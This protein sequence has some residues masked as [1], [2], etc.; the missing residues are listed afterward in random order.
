MLI[1][2]SK[3]IV[4][5]PQSITGGPELLHQLVDELR[6]H[7]R[8]ACIVYYPFD[9]IF[10]CPEP[11]TKY[12]APQG[13]FI[14]DDKN[15]IIVPETATAIA[16]GI[17]NA[18]VGIWWL[19][20]DNYL[21]AMHQSRL[22]DIYLRYKS[23]IRHRMPLRSMR[24]F[25]HFTQSY[26]AAHFLNTA[27]I[28]SISL[29]DYLSREHLT[30]T[31]SGDSSSKE[32]IIVYNSKKGQR[33]TSALMK[34][35]PNFRFVPILNMTPNQVAELL[36]KAKVYVDFGHHPGKDRPPREAAMAG[37]CVI[38]GRKGSA[39]FH[40]DIPIPE[41]YKLNDYGSAYLKTF[42]PLVTRIYK[43]FDEYVVDFQPYRDRIIHEGEIFK[44]QVKEIFG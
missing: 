43:N 37:C 21:L 38:T 1:T 14:D 18:R 28:T 35:Y 8:D 27:G 24:N 44:K 33:Q 36:Q 20:V 25:I 22:K 2:E 11:Y 19:S 10:A 13:R 15:F 26:Y 16:K 34:H 23:L 40:E 31:Y 29:T 5:C 39:K 4:C 6:N 17:K 3:I 30:H 7:G 41:K 12:N 32:D 42:G 9:R